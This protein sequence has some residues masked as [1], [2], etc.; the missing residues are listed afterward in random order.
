MSDDDRPR[1]SSASHGS[2][3]PAAVVAAAQASA[4]AGLVVN[5]NGPSA[6]SSGMIFV[7]EYELFIFYKS[8]I[9]CVGFLFV[10]YLTFRRRH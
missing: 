7:E 6:N 3:P 8:Y 2:G 9:Y 10:K 1:V 4:A 5:N